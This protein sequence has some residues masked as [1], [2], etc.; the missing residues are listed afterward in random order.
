M[1]WANCGGTPP[2]APNHPL[3][4]LAAFLKTVTLHS[5]DDGPSVGRLLTVSHRSDL[6]DGHLVHL[7]LRLG[8]DVL[9]AIGMNSP[10]WL[11][12]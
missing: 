10:I 9:T 5:L 2:S 8:D 12:P 4:P 11:P 3:Q 6:V 1:A 7:A